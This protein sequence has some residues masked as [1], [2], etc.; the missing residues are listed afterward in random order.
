MGYLDNTGLAY[1]WEKIK[2]NFFPATKEIPENADLN[3]YKTPGAY[4][5]PTNAAV[6]TLDNAPTI[7]AFSLI[8]YRT[9]NSNS[10]VQFVSLFSTGLSNQG[11]QDDANRIFTRTY[12]WYDGWSPW[13]EIVTSLDRPVDYTS[14]GWTLD[15]YAD[16]CWH[17]MATF[18]NTNN[19]TDRRAVFL[20]TDSFWHGTI[21][22]NGRPDLKI[23]LLH[24]HI[25]KTPGTC[26]TSRRLSFNLNTG[27]DPNDFVLVY[28]PVDDSDELWTRIPIR[29][30]FRTFNLIETGLNYGG[31]R[32][33]Q[34]TVNPIEMY[35][36]VR[37][38]EGYASYPTG[39]G[40]V[41]IVSEN[42]DIMQPSKGIRALEFSYAG[43]TNGV[44][45][46][47]SANNLN[48]GGG[49][50]K[51]FNA[52]QSMT[53]A[54]GKPTRA[55]ASAGGEDAH[56]IHL[57]WDGTNGYDS[58]LAV[59]NL[60][61][62]STET[63]EFLYAMAFRAG[64]GQTDTL[65]DGTKVQTY[66][67]DWT[68]LVDERFVLDGIHPD[69][70]YVSRY[71]VCETAASTGVKAVDIPGFELHVGAYVIVTFTITNSAAVANLKLNVS[72]TG[73]KP[74]KYRNANLAAVGDLI[75]NRPFLFVYDGT[76]WQLGIDINKNDDHYERLRTYYP[77]KAKSAITKQH[78]IVAGEDGLYF[79]LT[80]GSPFSIKYPPLYATSAI[81]A[82]AKSTSAYYF[83]YLDTAVITNE[84]A[85]TLTLDK[86]LYIKG[87]L[88]D[89]TFTP[90][91]VKSL[92]C[93]EPT[94][95]DGY[96][97]LKLGVVK[98]ASTSSD[99][100]RCQIEIEHPIYEYINGSF[101][102][103]EPKATNAEIDSIFD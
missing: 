52:T 58:Q 42:S 73:D 62:P 69:R 33:Y 9:G 90:F 32:Y 101:C 60:G 91:A 63:E 86:A 31:N 19:T 67:G 8:V 68:H 102:L 84:A 48:V 65:E 1:F 80:S 79:M 54:N 28:N 88:N 53:V 13:A 36:R 10:C 45:R 74:I 17:K 39:E 24:V 40:Y 57:P 30:D 99:E 56:I 94:T 98:A 100:L 93:T 46:L 26:A 66:W 2:S 71:G 51:Y 20:V 77:I 44:G 16:H 49:V 25:R 47:T 6:A 75:A 59:P 18:R 61:R 14:A 95:E 92:V 97:Y 41:A 11:A 38:S 103:Y 76:N 4:C 3:D 72:N 70:R 12:Y 43:S 64:T 29:Y 83:C 85:E 7:K 50:V 78:V 55:P 81:S 15:T 5:C 23:G 22:P 87:H 34:T 27:Y 35:R 82:N 21:A 89:T 96:Q 37:D